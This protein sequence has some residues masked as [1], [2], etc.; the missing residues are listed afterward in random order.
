[1]YT[2][3]AFMNLLWGNRAIRDKKGQVLLKP[4]DL[5]LLHA[6]VVA[7][8]D[9]NDGVKDGLIGD[10]R[11]CKFDPEA[12]RCME[13]QSKRCLA[14]TK[15]EAVE[16]IYQGPSTSSG[17]R[18][19][20]PAALKGSERTWTEFYG[21]P[22]EYLSYAADWFRYFLLQPNPGP[23]WQPEAFDFDRDYKRLGIAATGVEPTNPD[24]RAFK[25]AGGKL[26]LVTGWSDAIEVVPRTVDYYETVERVMGGRA[27]T[28]EFFRTFVVPGMEHCTDG[29]GPFAV[30]YLTYL[31]K[32]VEKGEAPD[33]IIGSHISADHRQESGYVKFPLDA[34][35]VEFSRPIYPYPTQTKYLGR[36]D[37]RDAKSFGPDEPAQ[38]RN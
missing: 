7:K 3:E 28:Q 29:D 11:E 9:L 8:C 34:T 30:D 37:S 20:P 31:E 21:G 33:R 14:T 26:M 27:P 12:L 17:L 25:A 10:P 1:M 19:A 4:A 18:I 36:G 16:K 2:T 13:D 6:A 24:L 15:L 32:W 5:E 23:T 35:K 38:P 22:P